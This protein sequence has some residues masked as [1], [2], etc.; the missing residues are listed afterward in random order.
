M[1]RKIAEYV[2][3]DIESRENNVSNMCLRIG[4]TT[5]I[6][7]SPKERHPIGHRPP[8]S[9][10]QRDNELGHNILFVWKSLINLRP[11]GVNHEGTAIE[12][13]HSISSVELESKLGKLNQSGYEMELR[14]ESECVN[15]VS[16][17]FFD[18]L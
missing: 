14:F 2:H 17:P 1:F 3:L 15:T 5:M 4:N 12:I 11:R 9:V 8:V 6:L 16:D 10:F 13:R 18:E 7:N